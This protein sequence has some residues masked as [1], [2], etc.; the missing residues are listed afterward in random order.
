MVAIIQFG[1]TL[2]ATVGGF[3][4]DADGYQATFGLSAALLVIAALLASAAARTS[5]FL[6]SQGLAA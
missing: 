6:S 5:R 1:I 2:G 4:Y 3:L